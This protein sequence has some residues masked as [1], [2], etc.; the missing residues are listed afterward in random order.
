MSV[1]RRFIMKK[2]AVAMVN[3]VDQFHSEVWF[4]IFCCF[5]F[6]ILIDTHA[7]VTVSLQFLSLFF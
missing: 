1:A 2:L 7:F 4:L 6:Q 3:I 5:F